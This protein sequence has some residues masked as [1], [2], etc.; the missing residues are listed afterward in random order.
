MCSAG[1]NFTL[2]FFF[3]KETCEELIVP[4]EGTITYKFESVDFSGMLKP[5]R[6]VAVYSCS[7]GYMLVGIDQRICQE[8]GDAAVWSANNVNSTCVGK[9]VSVLMSAMWFQGEIL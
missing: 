4:E 9:M 6:T 1:F 2:F 5:V 7:E 3:Y 8:S